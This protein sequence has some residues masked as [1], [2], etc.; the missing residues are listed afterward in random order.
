[1][2]C[3]FVLFALAL[4]LWSAVDVRG[5][6]RANS[7]TLPPAQL[8]EPAAFAH[9]LATSNA[10][11]R[12]TIVYVGV[13]T[14]FNGGHIPGATFHGTGSTEQGLL[15]LKKWASTLPRTTDIVIYCGCCPFERCPN[16]RPAFFQFRDLGFTHLRVLHLPTSFAQDWAAKNFPMEVVVH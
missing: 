7:E 10:D 9:E 11:S 2:R 1:M 15:E 6:Q 3:E 8:V 12:P 13:H 16:I 5:G 4:A 14:L